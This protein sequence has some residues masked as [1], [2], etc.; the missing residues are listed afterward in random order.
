MPTFCFGAVREL[1]IAL[2]HLARI[3]GMRPSAVSY[4]LEGGEVIATDNNYQLADYWIIEGCPT[5]YG[6]G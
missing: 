5:L 4:A 6:R 2:T 1:G 3:L